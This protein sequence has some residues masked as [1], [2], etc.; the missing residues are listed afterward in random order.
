MQRTLILI[1]LTFLGFSSNIFAQT[2]KTKHTIEIKRMK[3]NPAELVV[4][5][6][7]TVV[8]INHDFFPHDIASVNNDSWKTKPLEKG[9]SWTKVIIKNEDYFCPLH[10]VMKGKIILKGN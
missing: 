8:W 3:F 7:D 10:I 4:K 5:K 6:G 1:V 2:S 9:E